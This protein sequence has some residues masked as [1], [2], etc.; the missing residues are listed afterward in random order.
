MIG[1]EGSAQ[2]IRS[3]SHKFKVIAAKIAEE[4]DLGSGQ[5]TE[6]ALGLG[7]KWYQRPKNVPDT[8]KLILCKSH[9]SQRYINPTDSAEHVTVKPP[10]SPGDLPYIIHRT[11]AG[12]ADPRWFCDVIPN[13]DNLLKTVLSDPKI[14]HPLNEDFNLLINQYFA[15]ERNGQGMTTGQVQALNLFF[16]KHV[17]GLEGIC[18]TC[19][20]VS[21]PL[22]GA[23]ERW[24]H[25]SNEKYEV[26][27]SAAKPLARFSCQ[28]TEYVTHRELNQKGEQIFA[29]WDSKNEVV[30]TDS[31]N[32]LPT[33]H[34][35]WT[36]YDFNKFQI[37]MPICTC[38]KKL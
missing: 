23:G 12:F 13:L 10:D 26:R 14:R 37:G 25:R 30:G 6:L 33:T 9:L 1:L 15:S 36:A 22:R 24:T 11:V 29:T 28:Q 38:L 27:L 2:I 8:W 35:P 32:T 17:P 20:R 5:V 34:I 3:R 31:D 7:I 4:N 18:T 16:E 21:L 19:F